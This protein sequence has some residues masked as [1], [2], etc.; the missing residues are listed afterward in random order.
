MHNNDILVGHSS[1]S[2]DPERTLESLYLNPLLH[3][4]QN[5]NNNNN[6]NTESSWSGVFQ[7][8]PSTSLVLMLDFKSLNPGFWPLVVAQLEPLRTGRWLTYWE[9]NALHRG[10]ITVVASG[11]ATLDVV[12]SNSSYRDIFLDAPLLDISNPVYDT[13]NSYYASVCIADLAH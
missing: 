2:L 9:D 4:L 10:P 12:L 3:I 13:S 8:S 11:D 1:R 5:Q 6:S 7:S